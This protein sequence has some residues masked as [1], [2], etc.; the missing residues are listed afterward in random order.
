MPMGRRFDTTGNVVTLKGAI[1]SD[2]L[3]QQAEQVARRVDG[4]KDVRNNLSVR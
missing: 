4:V 3:R 2:A 1:E